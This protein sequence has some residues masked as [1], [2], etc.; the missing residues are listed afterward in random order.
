[1][2]VIPAQNPNNNNVASNTRQS[3]LRNV[4]SFTHTYNTRQREAASGDNNKERASKR[5]SRNA[6]KQKDSPKHARRKPSKKKIGSKQAETQQKVYH[7]AAEMRPHHDN[8]TRDMD[9]GAHVGANPDKEVNSHIYGSDVLMVTL[10]DTMEYH[11]IRPSNKPDPHNDN[12]VQTYKMSQKCALRNLQERNSKSKLKLVKT[13]EL[14]DSS[15]Y[16]HTAHD[17][18]VYFHALSYAQELQQQQ[19]NRV[20]LVFV[21]RWLA[22]S[23]YYCQDIND[24]KG[25]RYSMIS[26]HAFEKLEER[27]ND[28]SCWWNAMQYDRKKFIE[29]LLDPIP[30]KKRNKR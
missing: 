5:T 28:G 24:D 17:D 6:R 1:M 23:E 20:R 10:G 13:V 19:R 14:G 9:T 16:I 21:Y 3:R 22:V 25:N 29:T 30:I 15:L 8:G 11:L 2:K 4:E 27:S 7:L 12:I 18:E 26:K